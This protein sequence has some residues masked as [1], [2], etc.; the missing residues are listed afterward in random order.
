MSEK[1]YLQ[2]VSLDKLEA[3]ERNYRDITPKALARLKNKITTLG[4]FKPLLAV[5]SAREGFFQI[6]GGNQR[7][8][9]YRELGLQS[10]DLIFFPGLKDK[11]IIAQIAL[12]DNQSDGYTLPDK[13]RLLL[14]EADL[15]LDDLQD[16][17]LADADLRL[18]DVYAQGDVSFVKED[19]PPCA[20][21][22]ATISHQGDIYA[23]GPHR[24][25]CADSTLSGT[26]NTLMAGHA[27]DLLLTDPPYNVN[28]TSDDGKKISNDNLSANKFGRF[29]TAAFKTA[30]D[31]LKPGGAFYIWY[32][33]REG[34]AFRS[35]C[36]CAG[37]DIRQTLIWV[38]NHFVLGRQD[39]HWKHEPCLYGWKGGAAHYFIDD[40]TQSTIFEDEKPDFKSMKKEKMAELLERLF[41]DDKKTTTLKEDKPLRSDEHPTMKPVRLMARLVCN[42]SKEEQHVLD[43][44]G[45][46]GT[47][48]MACAQLGRI[49]HMAELDPR[50]CDVI[51]RRFMA[52]Y[53][54]VNVTLERD[55]NKTDA[56]ALFARG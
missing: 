9:A 53:P 8:R 50:Y 32:A 3:W 13:L 22:G 12:A 20:G 41:S 7:L 19:N 25:I 14:D 48:L 47:T 2:N 34:V 40:Y 37:L 45:G 49:C 11:K 15:K 46:S 1:L 51:V 16:F 27:A 39:Y 29:L 38:K 28:Y 55:G 36:E 56:H 23:L 5:P 4:V 21:G 18:S 35:A 33:H 31:V 17:A 44:F 26:I 52:M 24:L 43:P 6:I 10:A 42:S 54:D 30:S